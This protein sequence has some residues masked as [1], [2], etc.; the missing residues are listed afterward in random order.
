M[1]IRDRA[2]GGPSCGSRRGSSGAA[3]SSSRRPCAAGAAV[4]AAPGERGNS[5]KAAA[6]LQP[7]HTH[8]RSRGYG[9]S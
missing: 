3:A 5:R 8:T 6:R 7:T 9:R 1:C 4:G 2:T